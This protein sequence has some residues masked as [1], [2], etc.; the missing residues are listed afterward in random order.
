RLH[1]T[2]EGYQGALAL[3]QLEGIDQSEYGEPLSDEHYYDTGVSVEPDAVIEKVIP[4]TLDQDYPIPVVDGEGELQGELSRGN[5]AEILTSHDDTEVTG[6]SDD[7]DSV[8]SSSKADKRKPGEA[9]EAQS[10]S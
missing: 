9:E 10:T 3:N 2:D 6:E 5:I 1:I 8:D 4:D 7:T